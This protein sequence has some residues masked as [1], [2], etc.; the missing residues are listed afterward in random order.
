[1]AVP[2]LQDRHQQPFLAAE[3]LEQ[4]GGGDADAVGDGADGSAGIAVLG[5]DSGRGVDDLLT[6]A[7]PVR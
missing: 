2:V 7:D 1:M 5:E 3:V 6:P 4:G